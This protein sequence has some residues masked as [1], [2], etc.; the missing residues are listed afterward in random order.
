MNFDGKSLSCRAMI[1]L[2]RSFS[3]M[4]ISSSACSSVIAFMNSRIWR[5]SHRSRPSFAF[6]RR[7]YPFGIL[8]QVLCG[9][10]A[11]DDPSVGRGLH[12]GRRITDE[13]DVF[14]RFTQ[15]L[16]R[17]VDGDHSAL[18]FDDLR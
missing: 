5:L 10:Q 1:C 2:F 15:L 9:Q 13:K 16:P 3:K 8:G 14:P 11:V 12:L 18:V 4:S 17:I 7:S 6:I